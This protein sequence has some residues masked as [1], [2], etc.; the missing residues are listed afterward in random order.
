[1]DSVNGQSGV[2]SLSTDDIAEGV[3]K[4]FASGISAYKQNEANQANELL[5]LDNSGLINTQ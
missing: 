2:V 3:D 4:Y 5:L 1:M